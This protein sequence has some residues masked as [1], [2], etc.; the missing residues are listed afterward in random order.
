MNSVD[1]PDEPIPLLFDGV[2]NT[3]EGIAALNDNALRATRPTNSLGPFLHGIIA[4]QNRA[5][6]SAGAWRR[7]DPVAAGRPS[8]PKNV[9]TVAAKTSPRPPTAADV[10]AEMTP[11]GVRVEMVGGN[12]LGNFGR[13]YGYGASPRPLR[14]MPAPAAP[15]AAPV[16]PVVWWRTPTRPPRCPGRNARGWR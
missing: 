5:S 3:A 9:D 2:P 11:R 7:P 14:V 13:G 6:A 12:S 16:V 10:N 8:P 15:V 4:E 1:T